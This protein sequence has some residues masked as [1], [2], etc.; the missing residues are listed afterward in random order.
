MNSRAVTNIQHQG[1]N[2][3]RRKLG[4]Y[5][6]QL[7]G[8]S[9]GNDKAPALLGKTFR[10]SLAESRR[11]ACN[12]YGFLHGSLLPARSG[13]QV[14]LEKTTFFPG[15]PGINRGGAYNKPY[16]CK[17]K[18]QG[19]QPMK[20][21]KENGMLKKKML[22]ALNDQ[23]NAEMFSSYLYLSMEA[24]FQSISLTGFAAWMRGAVLLFAVYSETSFVGFSFRIFLREI[25]ILS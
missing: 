15:L 13:K 1:E 20:H 18:T 3:C 8:A 19:L 7:L 23:I 2:W 10:A 17:G 4:C 16:R 9:A 11:R 6:L 12:K 24:Y 25:R 22:K 5:F 21:G 14:W